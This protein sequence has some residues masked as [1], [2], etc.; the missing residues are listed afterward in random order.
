MNSITTQIF[1][2]SVIVVI[3]CIAINI[4]L[5]DI[6]DNTKATTCALLNS[7]IKA[8]TNCISDN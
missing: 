1:L 7:D 4:Y 6:R 2:L 5:S 3:Q 8:I